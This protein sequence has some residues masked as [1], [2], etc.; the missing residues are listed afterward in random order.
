MTTAAN[1]PAS[2]R[3]DLRKRHSNDVVVDD[4]SSQRHSQ[5]ES[6]FLLLVHARLF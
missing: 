2:Q 6:E 4:I 1:Q 5:G 3:T